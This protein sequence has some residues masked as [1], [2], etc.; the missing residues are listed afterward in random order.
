M[1]DATIETLLV[2]DNPGDARLLEE[3]LKEVGSPSFHLTWAKSLGEALELL[4]Q[5]R[6]DVV[7]LDL[8]LPDSHGLD[9]FRALHQRWPDSPTVVLTGLADERLA[10]EAVQAGSQ[11][12]LVKGQV[13][14]ELLVRS[15]RYAVERQRANHYLALM[16]EQK[17][18]ETAVSQMSDGI[19]VTDEALRITT[20]NRA[21]RLLLDLSEEAPP[22]TLFE[23]LAPFELSVSPPVLRTS[24][25]RVTSFEVARK[26]T[27]PPLY[28][29][30]RLTRL[31]DLRDNLVS[32]VL[33]LR[34]VTVERRERQAQLDFFNLVSHKLRTPLTVLSGYL[35]ILRAV[36]DE[37]WGEAMRRVAQ[38]CRREVDRLSDTVQRMLDFKRLQATPV[39]DG[40]GWCHL[41]PLLTEA[42][43]RLRAEAHRPVQVSLEIAP[44]LPPVAFSEDRSAFVIGHLLDNAVKFNQGDRPEV[45]VTAERDGPDTVDLRITDNGPGI[46]H[47]FL[48]RVF[49]G[50]VQ[51][52]EVHTGDVPGLGVGL[53]LAREL[54]QAGGGRMVISSRLGHGTTV[55]LTLPVAQ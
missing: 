37:R 25:E 16:T 22:R 9:T 10:V 20:T 31:F 26:Q 36:P 44:E 27:S 51:I 2:E 7:L 38:T 52:E 53:R 24:H 39:S 54:V 41:P 48:D 18:F 5:R 55:K 47:E 14:A 3:T 19:V 8:T 28:L 45:A 1:R 23:A 42:T 12:Y 50:F 15:I 32:A 17:R 43:E 46:P 4:G 49:E 34:D 40:G 13:T 6:F 35:D 21:A 33:T 29:D 11:D 30:A